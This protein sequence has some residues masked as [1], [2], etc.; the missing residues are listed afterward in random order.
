VDASPDRSWETRKGLGMRLSAFRI[1]NPL[2][3]IIAVSREVAQKTVVVLPAQVVN[4][5]GRYHSLRHG[6]HGARS[7]SGHNLGS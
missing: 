2:D 7:R 6:S 4:D 1:G 3:R 5:K